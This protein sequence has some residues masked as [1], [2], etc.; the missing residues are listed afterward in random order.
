MNETRM[1]S[2]Q[3]GTVACG[4][5][6]RQ[7]RWKIQANGLTSADDKRHPCVQIQQQI[8]SATHVSVVFLEVLCVVF[9]C[10]C[11]SWASFFACSIAANFSGVSSKE[12]EEVR[13]VF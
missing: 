10:G 12:M 5:E 7:R 4:K 13:F 3:A 2:L 11:S 6:E 1:L 8:P 9:G